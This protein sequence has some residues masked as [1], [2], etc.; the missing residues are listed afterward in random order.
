MPDN[1]SPAVEKLQIH[2]ELKLCYKKNP[3]DWD[4]CLK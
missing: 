2:L 1:L 4:I 3:L